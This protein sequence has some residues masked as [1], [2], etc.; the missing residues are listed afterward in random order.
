M[1]TTHRRETLTR[2]KLVRLIGRKVHLP[3]KTVSEV[4]EQ[5]IQ[6]VGQELA[7]GHRVELENFL[8]LETIS[9][10]RQV[11]GKREKLTYRMLKCRPG[12]GL[13]TLINS[14]DSE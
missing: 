7:Q 3:N 10:T 8:I 12:K 14:L 9:V 5:L 4:F 13:R 1:G 6:L 2:Q 11:P